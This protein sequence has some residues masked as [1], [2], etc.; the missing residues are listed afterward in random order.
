[1]NRRLVHGLTQALEVHAQRELQIAASNRGRTDGAGTGIRIASGG[2]A[3]ETGRRIAEAGMIENIRS[4][5]AELYTDS[6]F[7]GHRERLGQ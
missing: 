4:V 3:A 6:L 5:G 2:R 7:E 1:M